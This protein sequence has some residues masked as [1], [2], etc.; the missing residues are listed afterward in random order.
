MIARY[1]KTLFVA[2]VLSSSV[3]L[4]GG[5]D[6]SSKAGPT[7]MPSAPPTTLKDAYADDF[8]LGVAEAFYFVA[9]YAALADL[10]PRGRTGEAAMPPSTWRCG[11]SP[12][13]RTGRSSRGC[14]RS[15]RTC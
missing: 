1:R 15:R 9:G 4:A 13:R 8:L 6:P 3:A 5:V 12:A 7:T 2:L 10:A 11:S 14:G